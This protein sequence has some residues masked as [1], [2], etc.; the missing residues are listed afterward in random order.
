MSRRA[1]RSSSRMRW[2]GRKCSAPRT[3]SSASTCSTAL[4]IPIA[5]R[6]TSKPSSGWRPGRRGRAW[7]GRAVSRSI[8]R[9]SGS[10]R[11]GSSGAATIWGWTSRS[12]GPATS[13]S[14][15][16]APAAS[17]TPACSGRRASPR[18][19]SRI[20]LRPPTDHGGLALSDRQT[21]LAA[22]PR[23]RNW[24]LPALQTVQ[25]HER[26]LSPD[27]LV[28]VA[29]HLRVPQSEVYGVATHYPELRL[30]EPGRRIV[31]VCVGVSCRALGSLDVLAA[32]ERRL[33]VAADSTTADGEFTLE[34]LDCGFN[35]ALAPVVEVDGRHV[36]RVSPRDGERLLATQRPGEAA[37]PS[38]SPNAPRLRSPT[39][40]AE[41]FAAVERAATAAGSQALRVLVGAGSCGAAVGARETLKALEAE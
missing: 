20:P 35:C 37:R 27:A 28:A 26:W 21:T 13:P 38:P 39:S 29:G 12:P 31:R 34:R 23:E 7:R 10:R 24:L 1:T 9:S 33:A 4:D 40:V 36:G 15:T 30:T 5:G 41:S 16:G 6:N 14:P 25:H 22:F 11:P 19:A 32:L 8:P 3:S 17:A 2:P 18:P